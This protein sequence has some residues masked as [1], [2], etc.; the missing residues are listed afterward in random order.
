[1][2]DE[3]GQPFTTF[4]AFWERCLSMPYDPQAPLLPPKR[5]IPGLLCSS[6]FFSLT[7]IS[8][9]LIILVISLFASYI[10]RLKLVVRV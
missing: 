6:P 2:N 4:D 1:V 5:I 3:N 7:F 10:T 8:T 9:F